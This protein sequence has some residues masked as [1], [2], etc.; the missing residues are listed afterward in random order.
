MELNELKNYLRVE[1][2]VKIDDVLIGDLEKAAIS[3]IERQSGKRYN[4]ED[5]LM[6]TCIKQL[7]AHWYECRQQTATATNELPHGVTALLKHFA[8]CELYEVV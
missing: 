4:D 8:I 1:D 3:Y 2:D 5:R 7:V 6:Q